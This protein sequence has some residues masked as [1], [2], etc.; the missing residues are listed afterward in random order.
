MLLHYR[1][2]LVTDKASNVFI[3]GMHDR[4]KQQVETRTGKA[5]PESCLP[6]WQPVSLEHGNSTSISITVKP[7][8]NSISA[9]VLAHC[10]TKG[11]L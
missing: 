1:A 2:C 5:V 10:T 8:R 3:K 6:I 7:S 9:A 4:S 11:V